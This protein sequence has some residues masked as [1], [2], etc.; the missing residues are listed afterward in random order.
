LIDLHKP[1]IIAVVESWLNENHLECEIELSNYNYIRRDRVNE[2]KSRGGGIVIY[3]RKELSVIDV[4]SEQDSNIDHI[5]IKVLFK[6][7]KPISVG[8]FYR[9][10]DSN[11]D[12]L[13]FLLENIAKNKS[14][15][16]VIIGDF[17]YGDINWKNNTSGSAGKLFLKKCTDLSLHQCVK[18]KTREKIF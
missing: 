13:K 9:P 6:H 17:N 16:T 2:L 18:S 11:E 10:P 4:T 15:N 3:F 5:W 12:H 7:C 1:D 14:I 8:V